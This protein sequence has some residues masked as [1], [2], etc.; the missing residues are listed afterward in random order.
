MKRRSLFNMYFTTT[1]SISLVLF[2]VGLECVV[3]MSAHEL[4]RHVRENVVLTVVLSD[5]A[6]QE[7]VARLD[8][9]MQV[10][11]YANGSDYISREEALQ[12]HIDNL[13]EDPQKFLGYNPLTDAFEV[14]LH[15]EYAQIDSIHVIEQSLLALPYVDKVIYQ[16]DIVKQLDSNLQEASLI[17]LAIALAL[18]IIALVLISN[19]IQLQVYSKRFLINTMR[20]VGATPWVI[21]WP[22][23]RRNMLMGIEAACVA[24]LMLAA[25]YYYFV[26]RLGIRLFALTEQNI[27]IIIVAVVFVGWFITFFASLA[28]TNRYIRMKTSKMYEI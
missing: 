25:T 16:A 18:L 17:L 26:N 14:N 10:A 23:I 13:G 11:P 22:F 3:L 12:E 28:A 15:A 21:K 5:M 19:T 1:I 2:L 6:S 27:A 8:N 4:V 9:L 7:D 20:L 24:L